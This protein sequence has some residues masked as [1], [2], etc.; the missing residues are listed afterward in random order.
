MPVIA[1]IILLALIVAA[2]GEGGLMLA[3]RLRSLL[4]ISAASL[5]LGADLRFVRFCCHQRAK[6]HDCKV[7]LR[8]CLLGIG[9]TMFAWR[10]TF[11]L[12]LVRGVVLAGQ[13]FSQLHRTAVT[14]R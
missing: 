2:V 11:S 13:S 14:K 3:L 6:L 12:T 10:Q 4:D 5:L 8:Q 1:S 7:Y 9:S